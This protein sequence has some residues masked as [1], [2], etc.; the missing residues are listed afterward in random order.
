MDLMAEIAKI[1]DETLA[2][3]AVIVLM[4]EKKIKD[5]AN[6]T[7]KRQEAHF[8]LRETTVKQILAL[9]KTDSLDDCLLSAEYE[10]GV[11]A[12]RERIAKLFASEDCPLSSPDCDEDDSCSDCWNE[13][14]EAQE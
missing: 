3:D 4:N 12:E 7:E 9:L 6:W 14:L 8:L 10:R 2:E 1:V 13:Y 5:M 11:K